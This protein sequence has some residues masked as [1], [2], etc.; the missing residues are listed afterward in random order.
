MLR[1]VVA[2]RLGTVS[3]PAIRRDCAS[4]WLQAAGTFERWA[5]PSWERYRFQ[6]NGYIVIDDAL[7][8]G[9]VEGLRRIIGQR[10]LSPG[11]AASSQ[12]F[13]AH[14]SEFLA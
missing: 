7:E 5:S 8:S 6:L 3:G 11:S 9:Q 10:G 2:I 12:R 1:S 14:G 4:G 13:G